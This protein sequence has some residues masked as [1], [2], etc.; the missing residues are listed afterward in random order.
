M[1]LAI[2]GLQGCIIEGI[3]GRVGVVKDFLFDDQSSDGEGWLL[4]SCRGQ[5]LRL[6]LGAAG[7]G[8]YRES[9]MQGGPC[10]GG[11]PADYNARPGYEVR[12]LIASANILARQGQQQPC[13]DVLTVTRG[14]YKR[15]L[16]DMKHE[17]SP[18]ADMSHEALLSRFRVCRH[19]VETG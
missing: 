5:W 1:L 8:T 15:Y 19:E 3:D 2:T 12:I 10:V 4:V 16:S 14:L 17:G 7:V 13:E 11:G 6:S 18:A 9:G